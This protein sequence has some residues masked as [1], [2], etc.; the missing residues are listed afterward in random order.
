[1]LDKKINNF[2][3]PLLF[4][5]AEIINKLKISANF[6]TLLSF[7]SG[8]V[9]FCYIIDSNFMLALIFF[10]FNRLFDGL[11]GAVARINGQSDLGA[12][13]DIIS[14]FFFYAL[15]PIGFIFH[16]IENTYSICFLLLSFVTTQTT[17]LASA[18]ILEKNKSI[19]LLE[20]KKSFFYIGGLTEGFETII[21]FIL[22]LIFNDIV[23][24]IAYIFGTL[25]FLTTLFR[26]C[27]IRKMFL[28]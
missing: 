7:L 17:F 8:L 6:V 3:N 26:I 20:H 12:F 21:C 9:C 27:F 14:D 11:D 28:K 16:N 18:W 2:L 13:Y 24:I 25:C 10:F 5:I 19:I 1:M 15:F 22:M 4:H 23:N